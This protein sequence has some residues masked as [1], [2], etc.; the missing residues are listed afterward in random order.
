MGTDQSN[1]RS[2]DGE[3]HDTRFGQLEEVGQAPTLGET[4]CGRRENSR[5]FAN[6]ISNGLDVHCTLSPLSLVLLEEFMVARAFMIVRHELVQSF[7]TNVM[8]MLAVVLNGIAAAGTALPSRGTFQ[9]LS[10]VDPLPV[11][12]CRNL[13]P[14]R[15][16]DRMVAPKAGS[17]A[18]T[19]FIC[20]FAQRAFMEQRRAR[21][22]VLV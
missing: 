17:R 12:C 10:M 9:T 8:R 5:P 18:R 3:R 4:A 2:E 19:H 22:A 15:T 6:L 16:T 1:D 7:A 13:S 11:T 14:G 21:C 20:S